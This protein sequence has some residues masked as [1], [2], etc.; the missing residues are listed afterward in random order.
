MHG[1]WFCS[2]TSCARRCFLIRDDDAVL[3]LDDA[4]PGHDPRGG[5]R[6]VVELPGGQRVQ[7][8]ERRARVDQTV[9]ALAC[10][11]LAA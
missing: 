2:A 8:E 11:Q 6:S 9:D 3:S 1:R 4:D 10:S 7:L 5:R